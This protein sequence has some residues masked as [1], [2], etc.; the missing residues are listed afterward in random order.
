[1][2]VALHRAMQAMRAGECR[3]SLI[4]AVNLLLSPDETAGY[5]LM[6]FLSGQDQS[7]SFQA[8][9]DGYV[10]SEGV[11]VLLLKPL[12]DAERDGNRI[13]LK[14]K[15]SGVCHGGRG[16]SLIAPHHDSMKAAMVAAYRSAGV[17][18]NSVS[19]LEAH[20]VGSSRGDAIEIA[21]IQAARA[22]LSDAD[23]HGIPWVTSSLKPVIGHCELASGMAALFKVIDAVAQRQLPGI[24]GYEQLGPAI[25]LDQRQL[26]LEAD[27]R[28][29]PALKDANGAEL[30]RRA[31]INSYGFG[32][33]NAHLVVEEYRVPPRG[34][35]DNVGPQLILLSA[36]DTARLREQAGRF[37][38]YVGQRPDLCLADIAYTLQVGRT[39]MACRWPT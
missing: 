27:S 1:V 25:M 18:P 15:G 10:R 28:P 31:S 16:A 19:Y 35:P 32:G 8:G 13:Y 6:G 21:A 17:D 5:R 29:W 20:G 26:Q 23:N 2:L 14:I 37:Y 24:P 38:R 30:P 9:A 33:V 22:E 12:A 39:A 11:G 3:Q 36:R 34:M 7:R 4:G